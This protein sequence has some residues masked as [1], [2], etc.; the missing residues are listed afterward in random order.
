MFLLVFTVLAQLASAPP[1]TAV[2]EAAREVLASDSIQSQ[3][4]D[5]AKAAKAHHRQ[6]VR[7]SQE[8]PSR[9]RRAL[10][11]ALLYTSIVVVLVLVLLWLGRGL[12]GYAPDEPLGGEGPGA[13]DATPFIPDHPRTDAEALARSG[14]YAEAA[15]TLL[16]ETLIELAARHGQRL[17][18]SLTSRE[19]LAL[20]ELPAGARA[21]L[22]EIVEVV[23]V[24]HFGSTELGANEYARCL[25]SYGRFSQAL[26]GDLA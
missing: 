15:H 26:V 12:L 6:R 19:I 23:E 22:K 16:L 25:A 2:R 11:T 4:P 8:P 18:P 17:P 13:G 10:A 14:R 24:S 7:P 3:L 20:V 5:Q 1:S 21:A 9:F